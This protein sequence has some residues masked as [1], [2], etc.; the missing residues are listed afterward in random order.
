M[1]EVGKNLRPQQI[2]GKCC[3]G[4][5][6]DFDIVLVDSHSA[7]DFRNEQSSEIVGRYSTKCTRKILRILYGSVYSPDRGT[8]YVTLNSNFL[9][10]GWTSRRMSSYLRILLSDK[11]TRTRLFTTIKYDY[12]VL[13]N[14]ELYD[15][16][17]RHN[18][19]WLNVV[20]NL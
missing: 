8:K 11:R 7:L 6:W 5:T 10:F 1:D 15:C 20:C 3:D 4:I 14:Q 2:K 12:I 19:L 9:H 13:Y 16:W 18:N 17:Y